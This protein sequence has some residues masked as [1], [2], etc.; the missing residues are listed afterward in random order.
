ML[1]LEESESAIFAVSLTY[2][3]AEESHRA[4]ERHSGKEENVGEGDILDLCM[5]CAGGARRGSSFQTHFQFPSMISMDGCV[6][7]P[8]HKKS[9]FTS[10]ILA[11]GSSA[12]R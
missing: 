5:H 10:G 12:S 3:H 9:A 7:G 4:Y 2:V 1:F 11:G 6:K 8:C